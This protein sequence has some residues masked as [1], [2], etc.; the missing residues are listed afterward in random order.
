MIARDFC[1][2][3]LG[4]VLNFGFM[5]LLT[6]DEGF[7]GRIVRGFEVGIPLVFATACA[8]WS[9]TNFATEALF[10]GMAGLLA[11]VR[12]S[13]LPLIGRA[14]GAIILAYSFSLAAGTMFGAAKFYDLSH[15][16]NLGIGAVP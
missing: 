3:V 4:F 6:N 2:L 8:L 5:H 10:F 12:K 14:D 7:H 13:P 16:I 15:Y 9:W 11:A 1:I